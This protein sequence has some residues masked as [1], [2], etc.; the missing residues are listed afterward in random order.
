MW[1]QYAL[2]GARLMLL[3]PSGPAAGLITGT[4]SSAPAPLRTKPFVAACNRVGD[5]KSEKFGG[6]SAIIDPWGEAVVEA[7]NVES[8]LTAEFDLSQA[9]DVRRRIPHFKDRRPDL[10]S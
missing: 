1:C 3:L 10:Y 6:G 8:L 7:G 5:S 9:D 4:R 2:G